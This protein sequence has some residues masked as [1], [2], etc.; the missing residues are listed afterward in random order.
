MKKF[1]T[2]LLFLPYLLQA[3]E[4]NAKVSV[5][6]EK[7]PVIN[8]EYLKDFGQYIEDYLNNNRFTD[9]KWDSEKI[10]CSFDIFF[11]TAT[12]ETSY[13]AQ[14]VVTSQRPLYP[15]NRPDR[16][17]LMLNIM[18][19]KWVFKY[20]S[21]QA[22]TF[23]PSFFDPLTSFLDF[24]AF[25]IIGYDSDS[26]SKLG[27]SPFY[28]RAYNIATLGMNSSYA[29]GWAR[30]TGAFTRVGIMEDLTN[31]K[32]TQFRMD[33]F[34]YHYNGVDIYYENK[35]MAQQNIIKLVKNLYKIRSVI[36]LR[37]P[38]VKVFFLAK[39]AEIVDYLK[40]VEDKSIF[41]DLKKIDPPHITKYNEA[42]DG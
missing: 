36:D 14:V 13:R 9:Q 37:N 28:D 2:L 24:Y 31:E 33:F 6:Y 18:D 32:F 42:I 10:K 25:F 38:L 34:D 16:N 40:D 1:I 4:L 29:E 19:Q 21:G 12:S 5:N 17:S 41:E 35:E 26:F 22:L 3:Q 15:Y 39:S 30:E 11:E 23:N 7:L 8:K 27:G 20:E